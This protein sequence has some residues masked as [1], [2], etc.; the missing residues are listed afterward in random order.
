[1]GAL[2]FDTTFLLDHQRERRDGEGCAHDFLRAH[3][4]EVAYLSV[5]AY[6]E[7]AEGFAERLSP[8]FLS[9]V[10]SFEILAIDQET[11]DL[12]ADVARE[13]RGKGRMIGG[14]DLWI[15]VGALQHDLPV[16]TANEERFSR[17]P[18]LRVVG[19]R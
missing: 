11:A 4:D 9:V 8:V 3:A 5:V 19:Y 10:E 1:M 17:I 7:F 6:A 16:V 18:G 2:S 15:G 13:L 14:N 12:Y